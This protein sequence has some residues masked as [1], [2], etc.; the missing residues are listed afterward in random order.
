MGF[1]NKRDIPEPIKRQVR[2]KCRFSCVICGLPIY[3][4]DHIEEYYKVLNHDPD[5]ITLLCPNHHDSKG[6]GII[7]KEYVRE[8]T[9]KAKCRDETAFNKIHF[10]K[11]NLLFGNNLIAGLPGYAFKVFD[12]DFLSFSYK[13]RL[14]IDA[15]LYDHKGN[16]ILKIVDSEYQVL[17]SEEVWDIRIKGNKIITIQNAPRNRLLQLEI[18]GE[19][20]TI[21]ILGKVYFSE[22]DYVDVRDDGI[23]YKNTCLASGCTCIANDCG[24]A[25]VA[26]ERGVGSTGFFNSKDIDCYALKCDMG[27][28]WTTQWLKSLPNK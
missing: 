19:K 6:K 16:I 21:K 11:I 14:T 8:R 10:D 15:E 25:I 17:M 26:N 12:K 4:Y 18:N 1:M 3:Q 28:L 7:S 2:Q 23:F 13:E 27:F 24:I 9:A 5:N 22:N 20:N